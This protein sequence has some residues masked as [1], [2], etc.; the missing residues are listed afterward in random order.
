VRTE[1]AVRLGALLVRLLGATW[2]LRIDGPDVWTEA[3]RD[4]R[5]AILALWHGELLPLIW[6]FRGQGL[7]PLVS[8]HS[9]GEVI[10]RI[11]ELVGYRPI[12]GSSSRGGARALLEAVQVLRDGRDVA[13]TT[14]GPRGPRRRSAPGVAV[15]SR[16]SGAPIVPVGVVV[17]RAWHL[18]SWDRFVIPKPFATVTVR[19]DAPI[20][21]ADAGDVAVVDAALLRVCG[22]DA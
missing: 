4:G 10:A 14:D 11:I 20:P 9:D 15:A 1:A 18:R 2:R 17:N 7:A 6:H 5:P 13:F 16:K 19:F 21:P 12:R 22:P 3:R 8:T